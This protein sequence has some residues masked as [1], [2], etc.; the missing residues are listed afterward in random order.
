[1][2]V[3]TYLDKSDPVRLL[4][5]L[6]FVMFLSVFSFLSVPRFQTRAEQNQLLGLT[7]AEF[8]KL[9][10]AA[11]KKARE[12]GYKI[13]ELESSLSKEGKLFLACYGPKQD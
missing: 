1:M 6:L 4:R 10:N 12:R 13:E 2:R 5:C 9:V 8:K 11:N 7:D 3:Q